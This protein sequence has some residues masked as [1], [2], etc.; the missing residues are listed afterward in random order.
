MR[1]R[2]MYEERQKHWA[3]FHRWEAEQPLTER[4][5]ARIL[6][7]LGAV[8]SWLPGDVR[9]ADPDPEKLGIQA[10]KK[11]MAFAGGRR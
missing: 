2:E 8:L 1:A 6:A 5:P 11:G 3:A 9:R 4:D 10:L 7:D